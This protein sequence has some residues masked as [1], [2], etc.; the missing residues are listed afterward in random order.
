MKDQL[1]TLAELLAKATP[2]EWTVWQERTNTPDDAIVEL[3]FQVGET[4][5]FA[6]SLFMLNAGGKCPAVTGCGPTSEA[7]AAAIVA[8]VNFLRDNL[9]A[10][11]EQSDEVER[12]KQALASAESKAKSADADADMY[13]KAWQ[14]ELGSYGFVNKRH[15]IDAMV[16]TTRKLVENAVEARNT[17]AIIK[18]WRVDAATARTLGVPEPDLFAA[19]NPKQENSNG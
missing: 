4:D 11:R 19:L 9:P 10:I 1:D 15:H 2:G 14:R 17:L 6:G 16:L 7:N 13:A 3:A 8:A 18:Q 5:Q 12:L